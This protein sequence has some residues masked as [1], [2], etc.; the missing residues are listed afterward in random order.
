MEVASDPRREKS[1]AAGVEPRE[2]MLGI[3][4]KAVVDGRHGRG[5]GAGITTGVDLYGCCWVLIDSNARMAVA[6]DCSTSD[7]ATTSRSG[8]LQ[9]SALPS[10]DCFS[11][12]IDL[13]LSQELLWEFEKELDA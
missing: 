7:C 11:V 10:V 5:L 1:D 12:R 6:D 3:E 8:K 4:V 13:K 9:L 2:F